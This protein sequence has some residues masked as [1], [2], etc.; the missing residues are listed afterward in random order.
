[1]AMSDWMQSVTGRS[2]SEHQAWRDNFNGGWAAGDWT[3][4]HNEQIASDRA[5]AGE[6]NP[7]VLARLPEGYRLNPNPTGPLAGKSGGSGGQG[8]SPSQSGGRAPVMA[9]DPQV[10]RASGSS[11]FQP[12]SLTMAR[13]NFG[14]KVADDIAYFSKPG[15]ALQ[16]WDDSPPGHVQLLINGHKVIHDRGW[17]MAADAEDLYGDDF[18]PATLY[19]WGKAFA[20]FNATLSANGY[21]TVPDYY[22]STNSYT[23]PWSKAGRDVRSWMDSTYGKLDNAWNEM[24]QGVNKAIPP[25]YTSEPMPANPYSGGS[26]WSMPFQ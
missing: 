21:P 19:G 22:N 18:S 12:G 3:G 8:A 11:I 20:D 7:D 10:V 2:N 17:S 6:R 1:M 25:S 15:G 9:T 5:D 13:V 23:D 14:Q 4:T 24:V 26:A 16:P